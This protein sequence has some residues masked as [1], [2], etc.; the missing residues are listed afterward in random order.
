MFSFVIKIGRNCLYPSIKTAFLILYGCSV[1][2]QC[3]KKL[4]VR[5]WINECKQTFFSGLQNRLT[6]PR[7]FSLFISKVKSILMTRKKVCLHSFKLIYMPIQ[8]FHAL[9]VY[10]Y[11]H[12]FVRITF[13]NNLEMVHTTTPNCS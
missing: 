3:I 1:Y 4:N 5:A 8:F 12:K 7:V 9:P 13:A 6:S 2:Q 11:L 10:I